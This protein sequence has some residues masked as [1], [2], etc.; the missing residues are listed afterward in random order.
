MLAQRLALPA[1]LLLAAALRLWRLD[2][3]G[4][5]NDYYS[6]G[7]RSMSQSWHNFLYHAF[8][9][10]GFISVDK[11]PLALWIQVA[12]VKLFG[13]HGLAILV[14]QVLQGVA[15]VWLVYHLVQ[16]RFGRAAGLF[17]G[18][19]LALTPVSIAIDRSS[20][21]DTCL[22]LVLL[23]AAWVLLRA[24]EDGSRRFLLLSMALVGLGFNVKML[25]AFVVLPAFALV[26][27]VATPFVWRRR[28]VDAALAAVVLAAVSLSWVLVYDLTP[29][30]KRPYAGTTDSNSIRE[31]VVGPY[32]IGRF[33]RQVR[34]AAVA[35]T[36]G[37]TGTEAP[38]RVRPAIAPER[39]PDIGPRTGVARVFVRARV[40]PLRLAD[41][42][43]AGQVGW[44]LP[45][46]IMGLVL[47]ALGEPLRRPMTPAH[48]S[49]LLWLAWALTYGAVYSAAGG[50]FHFYYMSAL[51]PPLT[52]LAGI[53]VV[54][55]WS[56]Y[57][58]RGWRAALLPATLVST[59]A[60]QLYV[61]A[62]AFAGVRD[63]LDDVA[64]LRALSGAWRSW[65]H[66][67]LAGGTLVAAGALLVTAR[68]PVASRLTRTAALGA[69]TTGLLAVL[70]LPAAWSLSSVLVPGPGVLPSADLARLVP[71]YAD[72]RARRALDPDGLARLIEFLNANRR[73]ERYLVATSTVMLAGPLIIR[74]GEP[75]M[76]RG[77]FHGLDPILTPGKLRHLVEANEL[78]FVMLGDL[79]LVSRR[80]GAET[81]GQPI[82]D[83]VRANGKPVDPNLWRMTRRSAMTLYDLRPD[84]GFAR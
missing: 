69:L 64:T 22:V 19:F 29:A 27:L 41:G 36:E 18:L 56:H 3:N 32:G 15:S 13:F 38:L 10:A 34:P 14:P 24:A 49:L 37:E 26:Y 20:N 79:S 17:A 11:P 2:Q 5:G 43:L 35:G 82:A 78:R 51:A 9:P 40:G 30:S 48:L 44:L 71:G 4:Y 73:G 8:D 81:A 60:W 52:A 45:L 1:L 57:L 68:R 72:V 53:G 6:A 46:G 54:A 42:Q 80:M 31:L 55:L 39:P 63:L 61:D 65:L 62:H 67:A 76:A 70:I 58:R 83:W 59:A 84:L 66:I 23:L 33:V 50:F 7:V 25:A 12:S 74:T 28:L 77:G 21:T 75:V 47:G 16:R